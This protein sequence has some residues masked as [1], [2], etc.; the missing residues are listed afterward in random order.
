MPQ[1]LIE[2]HFGVV[3]EEDLA[4][5]GSESKRVAEQDFPEIVWERSHAI[6][7]AEGLT[8]FC[9][10]QAPSEEYVRQHAE[11]A[12]LPCDRVQEIASTVG[13]ADFG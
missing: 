11:K 9:I 3:S 5:G 6:V 13:P 1:Y 10:Y 12:G 4:K 7:T 8:T 2:R